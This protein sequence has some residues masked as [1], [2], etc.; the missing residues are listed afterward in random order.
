MTIFKGF[1][2]LKMRFQIIYLFLLILSQLLNLRIHTQKNLYKKIVV[3][4]LTKGGKE[5]KKQ[6]KFAHSFKLLDLKSRMYIG[7]GTSLKSEK[8]AFLQALAM[9]EKVDI[10]TLRLDRYY[11]GQ[12]CETFQREVQK[13]QDLFNS[14]EEHNS[15][16]IP[17]M[18][19]N[20]S[21]IC[22]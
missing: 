7:Y 15:Q 14:K 18:E 17:G 9:A 3:I 5:I 2:I 21:R 19:K 16:R 13:H 11:S 20:A 8:D 22:K 4:L 12:S 10:K 1:G 6:E